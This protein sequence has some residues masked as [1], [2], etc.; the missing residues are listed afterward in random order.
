[1]RHKE[2]ELITTIELA[3]ILGIKAGTLEK[4]RC[5]GALGIPF[6]RIGRLIRYRVC[7]V[8]AYLASN[9]VEHTSAT[10][11]NGGGK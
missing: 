10:S 1:M 6:V 4:S 8:E 7:D 11:R 2:F 9:L 3:E 5:T